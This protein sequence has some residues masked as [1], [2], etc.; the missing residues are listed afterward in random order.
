MNQVVKKVM[1][2]VFVL[3]GGSVQ[4]V[5][6][7]WSGNGGSDW[8]AEDVW[9]TN[10]VSSGAPENADTVSIKNGGSASLSTEALSDTNTFALVQLSGSQCGT[11]M[12]GPDGVL[13]TVTLDVGRTGTSG[14][15][16]GTLVVDGGRVT[17][18]GAQTV[19]ADSLSTIGHL[20][21][22]N[23]GVYSNASTTSGFRLYSGSVLVSNATFAVNFTSYIHGSSLT[24]VFEVIDSTVRLKN[25]AI[26]RDIV[27]TS[28]KALRNVFRVR[29]GQVTVGDM[30]I[31]HTGQGGLTI[32][33]VVEQTGGSVTVASG[34]VIRLPVNS[35]TYASAA[36]FYQ[37]D[38]GLL[39][40]QNTGDALYLGGRDCGANGFFTMT[41]GVF[42]NKGGTQ[43]GSYAR[44]FG[45]LS[46]VGGAA[47]FERNLA[48]GAITNSTG[49]VVLSGGLLSLPN[50]SGTLLLG[51]ASNSFGR[52]TVDGGLLSAVGRT[53]YVGA[54]SFGS[55]EFVQTGGLVSNSVT[56]VG[57]G[58]ASSGTLTLSNGVFYT[59]GS[60]SAGNSSNAF[61]RIEVDDGLLI[62]QS[63]IVGNH[64]NASAGALVVNG[65]ALT[66]TGITVGNLIGATGSVAIAGGNIYSTGDICIGHGSGPSPSLGSIG[67]FSLAG[68][69]LLTTGRFLVGS[70]G[71]GDATISGGE[72][73]ALRTGGTDQS[74]D[75]GRDPGS[76]GRLVMTGG[77]LK[78]TNELVIA[79]DAGST[80]SVAVAGGD[81]YFSS[82]RRASG[83]HTLN[84]AGGTLHPYNRDPSFAF[85]A[86]LTN[87]IGF[88][89]SGT[90]FGLSP[91][92]KDG[93]A[94][95]MHATC[96]F[97]GNGGLAKRDGGTVTLGGALRYTGDTVVEAGTLALSNAVAS[98][99]S[100]AIEVRSGATLDVSVLRS[101]PFAVVSNQTLFGAGTV[102]GPVS[103]AGG[104][105]IGGGSPD[106]PDTL[107][108]DGNLTLGENSTLLFNVLNG[109]YG[110]VHVT[111]DLT[112]P[113]SANLIVN[114]AAS[115]ATQGKTML[116]W[117]GALNRDGATHWSVTGEK[118]PIAVISA[119]NK[120]LTL[121]YIKG[122]LISVR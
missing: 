8:F 55:G 17:A 19:G 64:T 45:R 120:T 114:G 107:T 73:E 106:A 43:V 37:L 39:T 76:F 79:R 33:G 18:F 118:D 84:L 14:S 34:N 50:S 20:E 83:L 30:E 86:T 101:T 16:P 111:G 99:A 32:T 115:S 61:G 24:N 100:G 21:V 95:T 53:L 89:D 9:T 108:I 48:V 88:G 90:R 93:V 1:A 112:L 80:G 46:V 3:G 75:V 122:T 4:A 85:A 51:N 11:L 94:R 25:F 102:K 5:E 72:I 66:N 63:I 74:V 91:V 96:T 105:A 10:G 28:G 29:S 70:Y 6:R 23:G 57:S 92:D 44:G 35:S 15:Y 36:G 78:G 56:V 27:N 62:S 77:A 109:V 13:P 116:Y 81:L 12:V 67:V 40:I 68:G 42:T 117:D 60:L 87:D 103:L 7:V 110:C 104:A 22:L 47:F 26:G 121:S 97:A 69:R 119:S 113:A 98:L 41:D 54:G 65:G 49:D 38:G 59:A 82:V 71:S 31:G 58:Y 2:V 52:C